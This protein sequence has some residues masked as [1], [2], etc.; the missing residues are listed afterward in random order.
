[1]SALG[2]KMGSRTSWLSVPVIG[3]LSRRTRATRRM[4]RAHPTRAGVNLQVSRTIPARG[5]RWFRVLAILLAWT[6]LLGPAPAQAGWL[7]RALGMEVAADLAGTVARAGATRVLTASELAEQRFL[8]RS[9]I[10]DVEKRTGRLLPPSQKAR[11]FE[12]ANQRNFRLLDDAGKAANKAQFEARK[13][14][15]IASWERE[16]GATWPR[17]H[18]DV[19]SPGGGP[20]PYRRAGSKL[21]LHHVIPK[22]NGGPNTWWNSHP[23]ASP[24]E[25]QAGI[26]GG[27]S[28]LRRLQSLFGR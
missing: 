25:H 7:R 14:A 17:Y 4:P 27:N 15:M 1:M 19:P 2:G 28:A 23:A 10:R 21:D 26:H 16:T 18:A 13:K 3:G 12:A 24:S 6:L 8:A 11:I 9:Y 22:E 5:C 20:V